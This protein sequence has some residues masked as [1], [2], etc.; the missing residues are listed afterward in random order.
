M[1]NDRNVLGVLNGFA[2]LSESEKATFI[3]EINAYGRRYDKYNLVKEVRTKLEVG[4]TNTDYC[5]C[6]G[7]S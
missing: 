5:R 1:T 4:P 3:Q 6:C 7:K 2:N